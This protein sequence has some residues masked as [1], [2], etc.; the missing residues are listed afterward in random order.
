MPFANGRPP[1][2]LT[3][4]DGCQ[5]EAPPDGEVPVPEDLLA[6]M[7]YTFYCPA[8]EVNLG[9]YCDTW[10]IMGGA[11]IVGR[12]LVDTSDRAGGVLLRKRFTYQDEIHVIGTPL[13]IFP[14]KV[15]QEQPV[16]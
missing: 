16:A 6:Q 10:M 1:H 11:T 5:W 9:G 15:V 8:R 7:H 4:I 14:C 12:A 3:R 13:I 2:P